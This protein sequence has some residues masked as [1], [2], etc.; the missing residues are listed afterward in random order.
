MLA[1]SAALA[2]ALSTAFYVMGLTQALQYCDLHPELA[3]ILVTT[4]ERAGSI[5][6]HTAGLTA[7]EWWMEGKE[8]ETS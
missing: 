5:D 3:A 6:V 4:G 8:N 1:P 7:D 2:D